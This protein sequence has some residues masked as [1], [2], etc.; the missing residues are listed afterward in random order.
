MLYRSISLSLPTMSEAPEGFHELIVASGNQKSH[1]NLSKHRFS[2]A[3]IAWACTQL[4]SPPRPDLFCE[5]CC[6]TQPTSKT[7]SFCFPSRSHLTPVFVFIP[8]FPPLPSSSPFLPLSVLLIPLFHFF[9]LRGP[10]RRSEKG[11]EGIRWGYLFLAPHL[12][13]VAFVYSAL[14]LC[15]S[16]QPLSFS[17]F[18]RLRIWFYFAFV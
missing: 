8:H 3:E 9:F 10:E 12:S 14:R 4:S 1:K 15:S 11:E 5:R 2:R 13:F 17:F 6:Q 16:S 7:R 18:S